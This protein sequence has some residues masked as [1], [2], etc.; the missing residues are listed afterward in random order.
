MWAQP[1]PK[2]NRSEEHAGMTEFRSDRGSGGR[3]CSRTSA[4][5]GSL[6]KLRVWMAVLLAVTM[7]AGLGGVQPAAA[8]TKPALDPAAKGGNGLVA[9]PKIGAEVPDLRTE[10]SKT[11]VGE[12]PGQFVTKVGAGPLHFKDRA[13]KWADID[14]DLADPVMGRRRTKATAVPVE[15]ATDATDPALVKVEAGDGVEVAFGLAGAGKGT[16]GTDRQQADLAGVLPGVDV[17]VR[18]LRNGA[19]TDIVLA[20]ATAPAEYLFPLQLK[21]LTA[22]MEADGTVA[23]RDGTGRARATT[24]RG[25]MFDAN[26]DDGSN[27]PARSEGVE[28]TLVGL[29]DGGQ[30]L[31]VTLDRLWL[32]DPARRY[33]VT[34]DPDVI[35]AGIDDT[36]NMSPYTNNYAG[37]AEVKVG[38]FNGGA[39]KSRAF[40][41]FNLAPWN[42]KVINSAGMYAVE[43]HSYS[44]AAR[45]MSLYRVVSNWS[46]VSTFPGPAL[47]ERITGANFAVGY[48]SACP[49]QWA[50]FDVT[51]AVRNWTNGAW[52]NQGLAFVADN[53][54]DTYGWKKFC[55]A[56]GGAAGCNASTVP[57]IQITWSNPATVPTCAATGQTA[58]VNPNGSVAVRWTPA[59]N[60]ASCNGGSSITGYYINYYEPSGAGGSTYCAG[61]A[62]AATT[63]PNLVRGRQYHFAIYTNNAVGYNPNPAWTGYVTITAVPGAPTGAA[64]NAGK[65]SAYVWWTPPADAGTSPIDMYAVWAYNPANGSFIKG[66]TCAAPCTGLTLTGLTT[67]QQYGFYVYAHNAVEWSLPSATTA[68]ATLTNTPLPNPVDLP[69]AWGGDASAYLR[70]NPPIPNDA[71][72]IDAYVLG[73]YNPA[74]ILI[75]SITCNLTGAADPCPGLDWVWNGTNNPDAG[76]TNGTAYKFIV[77]A[78]NA[79]GYGTATGLTNPATPSP[80]S[81]FP[82]RTAKATRGQSEAAIQWTAPAPPTGSGGGAPITGYHIQRWNTSGSTPVYMD[83]KTVPADQEGLLWAELTNG[84][85]Y[86]FRVYS[87]SGAGYSLAPTFT[88]NVTPTADPPDPLAPDNVQATDLGDRQSTVTWTPPLVGLL[89]NEYLVEAFKDCDRTQERAAFKIVQGEIGLQL[90]ATVTGLLNGTNYCFTVTATN[91]LFFASRPSPPSGMIK[92]AAEPFAPTITKAESRNQA[93]QITWAPPAS[94]DGGLTPGDNGRPITGYTITTSPGGA[95]TLVGPTATTATIGGLT[96]GAVYTF[97]IHATNIVG[98]GAESGVSDSVMPAGPPFPPTGVTAFGQDRAAYVYWTPG[99]DNGARIT[100]YKVTASPGGR[101]VTSNSPSATVTG[102]SSGERYTFTVTATNAAGTSSASL[103]SAEVAVVGPPGAPTTVQATPGTGSATITWVAPSTGGD[104]SSLSYVVTADPGGRSAYVTGI[105]T[106]TIDQLDSTLE[107]RFR[108]V[109]RNAYGPGPS[110]GPSNPVTPDGGGTPPDP[111][112]PDV[113]TNVTATVGHG[114]STVSWSP[115]VPSSGTTVLGYT[116]FATPTCGGCAEF[117]AGG[118]GVPSQTSLLVTGLTNGIGYSFRVRVT[119]T[120]GTSGLSMPSAPVTPIDPIRVV[121]WNIERG[122]EPLGLNS[123]SSDNARFANKIESYRADVVGLQEVTADQAQDIVDLLGWAD[124]LYVQAKNPCFFLDSPLQSCKPFGNAII[125]RF[126]LQDGESWTLPITP[127]EPDEQRALQRA[128]VMVGGV[129]TTIYNTHLAANGPDADRVTQVQAILDQVARDGSAS[130]SNRSVALGDFNAGPPTCEPGCPSIAL[131]KTRFVDTWAIVHPNDGIDN[132]PIA[133]GWTGNATEESLSKRIDYVFVDQGLGVLDP[134]TIEVDQTRGLSD[135]LPVIAEV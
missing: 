125:S 6:V 21:G 105:T 35:V 23:Y 134:T 7:V 70:W 32:A 53:E 58:S 117:L 17:K 103:A 119:T 40:F 1:E 131:M 133:D 75:G 36:Y 20:S 123:T 8:A 46:T 84:T 71:A 93:A 3:T 5:Q 56:N 130:G 29:P 102:L 24:P 49:A 114:R 74:G 109:A 44:C 88:N 82:P 59:P 113:P 104:P 19:A 64:V 80:T 37:E 51:G 89:S 39:N 63:I 69:A 83:F 18:P 27:E 12:V 31:K 4:N 76:L 96:N 87:Q 86:G 72:P 95:T 79:A 120:G 30:A 106:A 67:G 91:L 33:P 132:D 55:S 50:G 108:V 116:V 52:A 11:F 92:P 111:G 61:A 14:A 25:Y 77:F 94:P 38:T 22:S 107:Y 42:G 62:C 97:T 101:S 47:A 115:V 118:G 26:V 16:A 15:V 112:S 85:S 124:P 60:N 2:T 122:L 10:D 90:S 48:S 68:V 128:V 98:S 135:H 41:H 99:N 126:P 73:A 9:Q 121:T 54:N 66:D 45:P 81:L 34:V 127:S 57:Q 65:T 110:S 13:D 100:S 43:T 129:P 78:R 28:Y